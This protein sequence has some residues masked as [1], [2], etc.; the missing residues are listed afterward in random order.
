MSM[1]QFVIHCIM[2]RLMWFVGAVVITVCGCRSIQVAK[3]DP[4]VIVSSNNVIVVDGGWDAKYWSYGVFTS[5]GRLEVG[6]TTNRTVTVSLSD[7]H[8]DMSANH[9]VIIDAVGKA[10]GEIAAEVV[11]ALK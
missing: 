9:V 1:V 3:H 8:T 4:T 7:F 2:L 11:E 6:V 5:L 10:A